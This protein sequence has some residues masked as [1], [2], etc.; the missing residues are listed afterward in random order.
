RERP[1]ARVL[2]PATDA[3]RL[4]PRGGFQRRLLGAAGLRRVQDGELQR[5]A[6]PGGHRQQRFVPV[7][8]GRERREGLPMTNPLLN[9]VQIERRRFL[10]AVGATAVTYPFLRGLPSYAAAS[11]G[12]PTY[13][14]LLFTPNG[15]VRPLWG[16][17]DA[18][19]R[20]VLPPPYGSP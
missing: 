16:A 18:S 12:T 7:P 11:G 8:V 20:D 6:A 4:R 3:L 2:R 14:V 15:C 5:Q 13:L 17:T 19:M 9:K 10:K 1:G